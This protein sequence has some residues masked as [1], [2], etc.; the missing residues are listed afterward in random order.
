MRRAHYEWLKES[1]EFYGDIAELPGVWATGPTRDDAEVEL[2]EALED[3]ISLGLALH[4][5]IPILDG[6]DVNVDAIV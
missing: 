3:W 2:R 1:N 6:I 4:H 5:H